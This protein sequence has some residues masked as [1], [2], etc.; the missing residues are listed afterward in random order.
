MLFYFGW[1]TNSEVLLNLFF[2]S[3]FVLFLFSTETLDAQ[4][5]QVYFSGVQT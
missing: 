4:G 5:L 3:F 1:S 2:V